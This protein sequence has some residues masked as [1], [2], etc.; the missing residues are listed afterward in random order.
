MSNQHWLPFMQP[1]LGLTED[2]RTN[3][4]DRFW[5]VWE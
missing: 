1:S 2:S 3:D 4:S 5:L